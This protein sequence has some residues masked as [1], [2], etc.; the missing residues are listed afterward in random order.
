MVKILTAST[1]LSF[2]L[3]LSGIT[4]GLTTLRRL[5]NSLAN[6]LTRFIVSLVS[7]C[8]PFVIEVSQVSNKIFLVTCSQKSLALLLPQQLFLSLLFISLAHIHNVTTTFSQQYSLANSTSKS[9]SLIKVPQQKLPQ[10]N[11]SRPTCQLSQTNGHLS[12][13][14]SPTTF[15]ERHCNCSPPNKLS[16]S[17]LFTTLLSHNSHPKLSCNFSTAF[18]LTTS[19]G[20]LLIIIWDCSMVCLGRDGRKF[21]LCCWMICEMTI[22]VARDNKTLLV[23]KLG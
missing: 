2:S 13:K 11:F 23:G 21:C 18:S 4:Q 5:C 3:S 22:R 17:N 12:D 15:S 20:S 16:P 14:I 1:V 19:L 9:Y 6:F 8:Q 7:A 10:T